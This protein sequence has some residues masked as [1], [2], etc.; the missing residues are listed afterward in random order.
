MGGR[1]DVARGVGAPEAARHAVRRHRARACGGGLR[2]AH[3]EERAAEVAAR[4]R[5]DQGHAVGG[6]GAEARAIGE[7]LRV[8]SDREAHLVRGRLRGGARGG[9]VAKVRLSA[10]RTWCEAGLGVGLGVGVGRR[11]G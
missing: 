5:L 11:L 9:C 8:E 1:L 6:V 4:T 3:V 10:R 7:L 2:E